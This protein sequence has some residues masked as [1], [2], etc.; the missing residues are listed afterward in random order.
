MHSKEVKINKKYNG[1]GNCYAYM[2]N[3]ENLVCF[4]KEGSFGGLILNAHIGLMHLKRNA[5]C[6]RVLFSMSTG[7][8]RSNI[9]S[10]HHLFKFSVQFLYE[11][12]IL[13][14][15]V[16]ESFQGQQNINL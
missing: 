14:Y 15:T 1:L 10:S 12:I 6:W 13:S 8:S 7:E 2:R 3:M 9:C 16:T 5:Y 4:L 11:N